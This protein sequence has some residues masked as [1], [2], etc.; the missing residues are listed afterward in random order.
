MSCY[1]SATGRLMT[2]V[3]FRTGTGTYIVQLFPYVY[4]LCVLC[5]NLDALIDGQIDKYVQYLC[6]TC[7][8]KNTGNAICSNQSR[9]LYTYL[10]ITPTHVHLYNT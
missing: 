9:D 6:S 5:I 7:R 2:T 4:G 1:C 8:T 10:H 3:A